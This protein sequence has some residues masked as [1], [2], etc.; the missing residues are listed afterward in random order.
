[1]MHSL[2]RELEVVKLTLSLRSIKYS[3]CQPFSEEKSPL[4]ILIETTIRWIPYY[5]YYYYYYW[6]LLDECFIS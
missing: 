5:Y 6:D 2:G 4:R 3:F 1:M